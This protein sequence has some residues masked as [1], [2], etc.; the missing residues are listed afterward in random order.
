MSACAD[1]TSSNNKNL[2]PISNYQYRLQVTSIISQN[3]IKSSPKMRVIVAN[4]RDEINHDY[5][6]C[7]QEDESISFTAVHGL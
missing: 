6:R 3:N 4:R 7:F 2:K 5:D 1:K